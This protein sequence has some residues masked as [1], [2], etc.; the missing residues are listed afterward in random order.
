MP[1]FEPFAALRYAAADLGPLVAPPYD[2]LS[3]AELDELEARHRHNIVHVDV[4]R[5]RDGSDRYEAA[6][7][8]LR[9]WIA[10]GVMVRDDAAV[11]HA[12]SHALH[13]RVW[14]GHARS[15]A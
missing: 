14:R 10:D 11:V 4:P 9:R 6:A 5:E 2:V 12:V 13:R 8:E 3:D 15:S 7:T 1:R